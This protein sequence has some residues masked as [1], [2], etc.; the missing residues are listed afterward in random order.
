M[1][2]RFKIG[3]RKW[4]D[5]IHTTADA[6]D[7]LYTGMST[8]ISRGAV[9]SQAAVDTV[10]VL[11]MLFMVLS[12]ALGSVGE[13][14]HQA[15]GEKHHK[16]LQYKTHWTTMDLALFLLL[17][18]LPTEARCVGHTSDDQLL[19]CCCEH[20]VFTVAG[21]QESSCFPLFKPL[22]KSKSWGPRELMMH[23][24]LLLTLHNTATCTINVLTESA[25]A[26]VCSTGRIT[27]SHSYPVS[28]SHCNNDIQKQPQ[29][30]N[31]DSTVKAQARPENTA[32]WPPVLIGDVG[33]AQ[34]CVTGVLRFASSCHPSVGSVL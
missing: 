16:A 11:F 12:I 7:E 28:D 18:S 32:N 10:V 3:S 5:L 26:H 21:L 31:W 27:N 23:E 9:V 33:D 25:S 13:I 8:L 34:L 2:P 15:L 29:Q 20:E 4:H 30:F 19:F 6:A 17:Y 22:L 24:S 1:A 14:C